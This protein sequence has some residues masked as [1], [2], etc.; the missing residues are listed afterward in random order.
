MSFQE[1]AR[2]ARNIIEEQSAEV[3]GYSTI[4]STEGTLPLTVSIKLYD[5][6]KSQT[7]AGVS[8]YCG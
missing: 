5:E 6:V 4:I 2:K 3:Y 7:D 1:C 8:V